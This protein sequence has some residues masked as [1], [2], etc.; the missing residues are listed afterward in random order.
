MKII[1][2]RLLDG[3]VSGFVLSVAGWALASIAGTSAQ[4]Y[5]EWLFYAG[6]GFIVLAALWGLASPSGSVGGILR[7]TGLIEGDG[8][9]A[10]PSEPGLPRRIWVDRFAT[11]RNVWLTAGLTMLGLSFAL[12]FLVA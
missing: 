1:L 9:D 5:S 12:L 7:W 3:I 4:R 10:A 2:L 8:P 11:S 6:A